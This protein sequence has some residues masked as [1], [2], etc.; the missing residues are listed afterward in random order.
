MPRAQCGDDTARRAGVEDAAFG[1]LHDQVGGGEASAREHLV[2]A[3]DDRIGMQVGGSQV[4]RHVPVLPYP[5][6]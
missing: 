5:L 6:P 4:D 2:E 1:D 3:C